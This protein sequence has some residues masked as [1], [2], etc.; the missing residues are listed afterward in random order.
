MQAR[1]LAAIVL[2]VFSSAQ[3]RVITQDCPAC[4]TEQL[5]AIAKPCD[6]G[7]SYITNFPA[8]EFYKV[9]YTEKNNRKI[10]DWQKP[11]PQYH[12][13]FDAYNDVYKLNGHHQY[14]HA[15]IHVDIP[16]VN[17]IAV[18]PSASSSGH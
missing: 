15:T 5:E 7:F 3:A 11:E 8:G 10:Y 4:S 16:T 17:G 1:T 2:L 6:Q 14:V 9:C 18:L 13:V 12:H